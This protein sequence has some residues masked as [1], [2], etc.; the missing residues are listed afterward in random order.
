MFEI[1]SFHNNL[2]NFPQP[3]NAEN[4]NDV[5]ES[6]FVHTRGALPA[7]LLNT[8]RPNE[9][10]KVFEYRL[11]IYEPITKG[12]MNKAIDK[13]FR[14]FSSAN[15]SIKVSSDLEEYLSERKFKNEQFIGFI[16]KYVLRRMI[17]DPNAILVTVPVGEGLIDP[18]VKIEV[19]SFIVPSNLIRYQT[20]YAVTWLDAKEKSIIR[21]A[22]VETY[23]GKIYNTLTRDAYYKHVQRGEQGEQIF[24]LVEVYRHEIGI[25]PAVILG[26]NPTVEDYFE[27]YFSPFLP[28]GNETI[29]Q[30]SDWCGVMTMS[31]FPYREEVAED[32]SAKGCRSGVIFNKET[33][34][35]STCHSCKGSGKIFARSPYGVFI[36]SKSSTVFEGNAPDSAPMVRFISPP[37][38]IIKYSGEAWE[39]LLRKAE[40][41]L[42]LLFVDESQSGK[43]KEIDREESDSM[44]TKISNNVFDEI[45]YKTLYFMERFRELSNPIDP[46]IIKPISFRSRTEEDLI[47]EI[48]QLSDKNAPIAF[49]VEAAKDLA[50]KRFSGNKAIARMV[51]ILVAYDPIYHVKTADKATLLASGSIKKNDIVKSLFAYKVL[52]EIISERGTEF[53]ELQLNEIFAVMDSGLEKYFDSEDG[54][55]LIQ[56]PSV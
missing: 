55:S 24:D 30:Y 6:M 37:V 14:L 15:Y 52:N 5:R 45:I 13:L 56:I 22:G 1:E 8:R 26:G 23:E 29:R 10:E 4:W 27:S 16:Q 48:N 18:S 54:N 3:E 28:F 34:E 39:N 32:C 42:H 47:Q 17:E 33:E 50:R 49:Q 35:H 12:S 53:L 21:K 51:E 25:V 38:D 9:D 36:R 19:D 43:A 41:S 44:L 46:Q 7:K 31:A 11:S 40:E 20:E 2:T